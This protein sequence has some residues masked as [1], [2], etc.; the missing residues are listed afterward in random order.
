[1]FE[2]PYASGKTLCSNIIRACV[3]FGF[4]DSFLIHWF[5]KQKTAELNA[6]QLLGKNINVVHEVFSNFPDYF[7]QMVLQNRVVC[8]TKKGDELLEVVAARHIIESNNDLVIPE[9]LLS[10][11]AILCFSENAHERLKSFGTY[12]LIPLTEIEVIRRWAYFGLVDVLKRE[13]L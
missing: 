2:G 10:C 3:G 9:K 11:T 5:S 8:R 4:W 6:Y 12:H 7:I 1:M 13:V